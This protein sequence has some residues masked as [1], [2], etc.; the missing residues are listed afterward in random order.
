MR[1]SRIIAVIVLLAVAGGGYWYFHTQR[2]GLLA[3]LGLGGGAGDGQKPAGGPPKGKQ[4][5]G[6]PGGFALPVETAK[7]TPGRM[8]RSI[9]AIGTLRSNQSVVV[10]PEIAGRIVKI[11]FTEGKRIAAGKPLVSLDDAIAK[12]EVAQARA[13]LVLSRANNE[14]AT[15]LLGRGAG[16]QRARDEAV[17]KLRSDE[18]NLALAEARLEKTVINAPFEGI[19]GLRQMDPGDFVNVGQA[20]VNI[21][22]IDPIKV[23]F[24]VPEVFLAAVTAGQKIE[25]AADPWPDRTFTGELYAIDP[26]ID[27]LGRSIVIRAR[28]DNDDN[29]LR[30]GLFV[31]VKLILKGRAD[32]LLIPEEALVPIGGDQYV[33]R[34][35]DGKATRAKIGIGER[36]D[37]KVE[38][39]EGLNPGDEVVTAGQIKLRD[40]MPVNPIPPGGTKGPPGAGGPNAGKP[41]GKPTPNAG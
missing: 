2:P 5:G 28:L 29:T 37:G 32:A 18:A 11:H 38:V 17:A 9:S 12:A 25:I 1:P 33:F 16:T 14:R 40:G 19:V 31:R 35:V 13:A 10:R 41:G 23:D 7:A 4:G 34:V 30:P 27:A 39:T 24:R 15:E 3:D 22:D 21:E 8:D 36:R 20:I 6:P 26:L